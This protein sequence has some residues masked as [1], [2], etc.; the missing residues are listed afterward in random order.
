MKLI[1]DHI[2]ADLGFRLNHSDKLFF[3]GSCFSQ[4]ILSLSSRAGFDTHSNPSGILFNPLSIA[5]ELVN[6]ATCQPPHRSHFLQRGDYWYSFQAHSTVCAE[7]EESL[8][9]LI[10]RSQ[11]NAFEQL[12]QSSVAFITL[13]SAYYYKH[14][15]LNT[16]VG[17]CHKQAQQTFSKQLASVA[18]ITEHFSKAIR[19]LNSSFP[20]LKL[21]F[22]VSPVRHLRDGLLE[23]T[24][25]KSTL[26]LATHS[27]VNT[28][29]NCFY[30]PAY[31]LIAE[32]LKDYRFYE[33]DLMH[34][35]TQAIDYVWQKFKSCVFDQ[36]TKDLAQLHEAY[37]KALAHRSTHSDATEQIKFELHLNELK[38]RIAN[39]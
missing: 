6:I 8:F 35:N 2:P 4:N 34:P 26:L 13:G 7:S 31:E 32:D 29:S 27:I 24:L 39:F 19:L 22:T 28:E 16:T 23:N 10:N 5:T 37:N 14:L 25:S 12:S 18:N 17:N 33:S 36:K 21:V 38:S 3:I 15:A 20:K 11:Q 9:E 30:F 1:L